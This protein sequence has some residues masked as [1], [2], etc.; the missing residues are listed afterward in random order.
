MSGLEKVRLQRERILALAAQHGADRIRVFGSVALRADGPDSDIDFLVSMQ[1][2][3]DLFDLLALKRELDSLLHQP[4]DVV[5]DEE[6]S[7]YLRQ[8]IQSEAVAV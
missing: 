5:T 1:P 4:A 3:R 2:D 6:L 7:P 8:R